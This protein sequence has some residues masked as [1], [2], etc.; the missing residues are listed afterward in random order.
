MSG[1]NV[2]D[3]V[4]R[5]AALDHQL[6]RLEALRALAQS[7]ANTSEVARLEVE[8]DHV[9]KTRD[10]LR[11]E[12]KALTWL[13]TAYGDSGFAT[14]FFRYPSSGATGPLSVTLRVT[15]V[16]RLM[17]DLAATAARRA[18]GSVHSRFGAMTCCAVPVTAEPVR[19]C[20]DWRATLRL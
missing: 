15:P 16:S 19:S 20:I 18:C 6:G 11:D 7:N 2:A 14:G 9:R 5:L 10:A 13:R 3:I 8:I 4:D 17:S 1:M 12:L